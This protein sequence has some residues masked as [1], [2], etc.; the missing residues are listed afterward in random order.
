MWQRAPAHAC[1]SILRVPRYAAIL[2]A[3]VIFGKG[4]APSPQRQHLGAGKE[5]PQPVLVDRSNRRCADETIVM[6]RKTV[7]IAHT[8]VA[9]PCLAWFQLT[10]PLTD[11]AT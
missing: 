5:V 6:H 2:T 1:R 8:H 11:I 10:S 4:I 9:T 7:I 3:M